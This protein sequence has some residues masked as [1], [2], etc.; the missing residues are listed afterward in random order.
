MHDATA[1][2]PCIIEFVTQDGPAEAAGLRGGDLV[3]AVE[4][5][6]IATCGALLDAITSHAPGD[7]VEIK[8]QRL[9]T[10]LAVRAQLTTRD[11]LL[12]KMIGKPM[13]ETNF[14][15]VDDGTSYDLSSLHGRIAIVGLYNPSCVDCGSLFTKLLDWARAAARKGG[16]QPLVVAVI[17]SE[18]VRDVKAL[19]RSLDVPLA[20]GEFASS[21]DADS[22]L[23]GRDLVLFDADRLGVVVIDSRGIVQYLGP[24]APDSDDSEAVLEEVFTVA[25]HA[26]RAK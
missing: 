8:V 12:R 13:V 4:R 6:P 23:F 22:A 7:S 3:L 2:G 17:P 26:L 24:I 10:S 16:Q 1:N 5:K 11:A 21:R 14:I 18:Q 15:G 19:Q 9:S 25:D 20:I